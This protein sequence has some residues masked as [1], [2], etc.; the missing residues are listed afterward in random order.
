[1]IKDEMLY[2]WKGDRKKYSLKGKLIWSDGN[3]EVLRAKI[4]DYFE[5]RIVILSE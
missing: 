4:E 1:V 3:N 5:D 2:M